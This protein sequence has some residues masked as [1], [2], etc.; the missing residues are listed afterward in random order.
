MSK[1]SA[2]LRPV[3]T[4]MCTYAV[5]EVSMQLDNLGKRLGR[6]QS[7]RRRP[8]LVVCK[9]A[10]CVANVLACAKLLRNSPDLEI[11]RMVFINPNLTKAEA[12][13]AYELRCQRRLSAQRRASQRQVD[14]RDVVL[15]QDASSGLL[16]DDHE[17]GLNANAVEWQSSLQQ[18][19][20]QQ[21]SL[22]PAGSSQQ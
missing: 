22:P 17:K 15:S 2:N 14:N 12:R 13:A 1:G 3:T 7:E 19:R 21:D 11:K 6:V 16:T 4:V 18:Q 8:I 10:D 5:A 20:Q 9:S